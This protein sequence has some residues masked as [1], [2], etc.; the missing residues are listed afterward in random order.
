RRWLTAAVFALAIA[1]VA[2]MA[3]AAA[4]SHAKKSAVPSAANSLLRATATVDSCGYPVASGT[5]SR[6][7]LAT[8]EPSTLPAF[9]PAAGGVLTAGTTMQAFYTDEHALTLGTA[10]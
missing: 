5:A 8:A 4:T 1:L 10:N 6:D 9:R 3:A 7:T 2:A